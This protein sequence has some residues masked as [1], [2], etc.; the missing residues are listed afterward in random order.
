MVET[1]THVKP[2]IYRDRELEFLTDQQVA[3][4]EAFKSQSNQVLKDYPV[5]SMLHEDVFRLLD[6]SSALFSTLVIKTNGTLPYTSVFMQ[7]DC[8]YWGPQDEEALRKEMNGE[9]P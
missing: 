2:V 9:A 1:S 6:E 5:N 4:I 3:G 7:L 8:S